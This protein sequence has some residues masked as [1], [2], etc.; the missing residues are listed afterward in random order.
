MNYNSNSNSTKKNESHPENQDLT[1]TEQKKKN[2]SLTSEF[3][4][5]R[6]SME[7]KYTPKN[8]K[9]KNDSHCDLRRKSSRKNLSI[10]KSLQNVE[11]QKD[12]Y[13]FKVD[14]N[15]LMLNISDSVIT[16]TKKGV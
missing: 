16:V 3:N 4:C 5:L 14:N 1:L 7:N 8:F 15:A 12:T 6:D 9:K 2:L 13:T 10:L 11:L